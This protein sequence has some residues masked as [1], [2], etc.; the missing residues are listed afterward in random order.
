MQTRIQ[1]Y[2]RVVAPLGREHE[3]VGP[4]L[5]TYSADT[6][7][8]YLNY[9]IPDNGCHPAMHEI[10][11]LIRAFERRRRRPRLEYIS[12]VAPAVEEP[13]I[14][15]G[16]TVEGQL[17]LMITS[18]SWLADWRDP[19]GISLLVP[20]TDDDLYAMAVV[21]A[22]AF[23]DPRAPTREVVARRREGLANG[24]L[25]ILA[26]DANSGAVVGAGSCSPIRDG[27][28]EVAGIGVRAEYRRRGI[29]A[30]LAARL[31]REALSKGADHPWLMAAH[32]AERRIYER[33]GFRVVGEILHISH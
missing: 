30:G 25:A 3:Q 12:L 16:F 27:L 33:V 26:K 31:A 11:A 1:D 14:A 4:F 6:D 21:Q 9:A 8:P 29:G 15:A 32:E 18:F 7:N 23:Q 19:S 10:S 13:L 22:E 5:C 2:L 24:S 17:P 28:T 20:Q